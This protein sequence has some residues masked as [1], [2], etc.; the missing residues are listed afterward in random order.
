MMGS[1]NRMMG[2]KEFVGSPD[3]ARLQESKREVPPVKPVVKPVVESSVKP[4]SKSLVKPVVKR[5]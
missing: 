2:F 1:R 5:G 3:F 4:V